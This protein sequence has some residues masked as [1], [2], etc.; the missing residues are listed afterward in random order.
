MNLAEP[1]RN[2]TKHE[3]LIRWMNCVFPYDTQTNNKDK[4]FGLLLSWKKFQGTHSEKSWVVSHY[5]DVV[6]PV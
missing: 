3:W 2:T 5:K 4:I 6:L 1:Q